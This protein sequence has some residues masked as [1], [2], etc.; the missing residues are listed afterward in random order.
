MPGF[1][2]WQGVSEIDGVSPVVCIV[3]TGSRNRK[4]GDMVQTWILRADMP[5]TAAVRSGADSAICGDCVFRGDGAGKGRAC[6]VV[7]PQAPLMIWRAFERG[8][9]PAI[10]L[11]QVGRRL[12]GQRVRLGAY[13]DPAALPRDVVEALVRDAAGW[14]GYT[15]QWRQGP[16]W[17]A[18]Y[19]MASVSSTLERDAARA[20]GY[21]AFLALPV[22][23][24][25]GAVP[26]AVR[27]PATQDG[28]RKRS[29]VE[30]MACAGTRRGTVAGAV[31]IALVAH[32]S[33]A[34]YVV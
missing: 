27:C 34:G 10:P 18:E 19:C 29:C 28:P 32:G 17:L 30:C 26:G 15:H 33:G 22:G 5:P 21:R 8:A 25:A 13:G 11:R 6:Y 4:T 23:S 3:T 1:V 16:A 20:M 9:Y 24:D 2:A 31:D 12:A 14:V 7:V